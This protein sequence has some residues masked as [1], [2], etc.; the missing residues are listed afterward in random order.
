MARLVTKTRFRLGIGDAEVNNSVL[1]RAWGYMM[2]ILVIV[3]GSL[4]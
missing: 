1:I 2:V 4:Q 3:K